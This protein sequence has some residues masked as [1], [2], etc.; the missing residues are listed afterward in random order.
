MAF[1]FW[2]SS[3]LPQEV[4]QS[5][6]ALAGLGRLSGV[7]GHLALYGIL[8]ALVH[9]S[10]WSWRPANGGSF[11]WAMATVVLAVLYG[12]SDEFHQSLVPGREPSAMDVLIDGAG[13]L[14]GIIVVKYSAASWAHWMNLADRPF[15]R[16]EP[17]E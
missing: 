11:R 7:L 3:L 17:N 15:H 2:A 12:I 5:L 4:D 6:Q 16:T 9:I 1:I 10:L 14:I 13:A 8:A